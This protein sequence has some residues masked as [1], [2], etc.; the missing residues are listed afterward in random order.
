MDLKAIQSRLD[1]ENEITKTRDRLLNG[2]VPPDE[3]RLL[4]E[5]LSALTEQKLAI[6]EAAKPPPPVSAAAKLTREEAVKQA[7]ALRARPE[8]LTGWRPDVDDSK[9]ISREDHRKLVHEVA[10]LDARVAE[11]DGLLT[12]EG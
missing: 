11:L 2:Y 8:C 5:K 3:R 10:E 7:A 12:E 1:L 9:Q 4:S 6:E